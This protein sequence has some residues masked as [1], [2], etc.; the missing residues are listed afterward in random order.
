VQSGSDRILAAMNRH[1]TKRSYL[2]L[3][4]RL[5]DAMPDLALSTD[6]IV[7]FP[8][9]TEEDFVDTLEVVEHSRYDQAFTFIYSPR[10]GTPA[11]SLGDAVPRGVSQ[12]RF[13]RLVERVQRSALTKNRALAGSVQEVLFTGVS[14][15]DAQVLSGRS[16]GNKVVHVPLRA[17]SEC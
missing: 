8:G 17:R 15:R 5:Y 4:D 7:G 2:E 12:G 14:K 13:D 10:E 9:E 11:A 3:V 6:V 1:Y 16:E